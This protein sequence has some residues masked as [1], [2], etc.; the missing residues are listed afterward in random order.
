MTYRAAYQWAETVLAEAGVADAGIDARLLLE[1]VCHTSRHDM[2]L[3]GNRELSEE[4]LLQF[5]ALIAKRSERIPLQQITG[6][7]EFMGFTFAVNEHVLIPRQDTEIL[8]EQALHILK[9]GMSVLDMCTGSGCILLSLLA[10]RED[11]KGLGADVSQ[12]ALKVA[13]QNHKAIE[14]QCGRVLEADFVESDLFAG[15]SGKYDVI[16]SNP[17]YIASEVIKTLELEVRLHEPMGA[18]DGMADG[19]FFYKEIVEKCSGFLN[20][21]GWLLFEIG[22]DQGRAV[23]GLMQ[24]AGFYKVTVKKDYAG[25]DRVVMGKLEEI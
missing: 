4:E 8:A 3:N 24:S 16:V 18:L 15:V 13:A 21:G 25:L 19:L 9:P 22:Y 12:E 11:V 14:K 6:S 17:P 23:A 5:R 20:P 1:Y 7:Q 10:C 2:I